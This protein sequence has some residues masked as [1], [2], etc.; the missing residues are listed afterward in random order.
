[1]MKNYN[2][3][4]VEKQQKCQHCHQ[5]K[6]INVN[7]LEVKKY[8]SDQSRMLEQTKFTYYSLGYAFEK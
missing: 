6:L 5:V 7:I 8:S 2:M 3:I 4:L 1:M